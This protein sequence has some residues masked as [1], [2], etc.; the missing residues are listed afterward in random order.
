MYM[1]GVYCSGGIKWFGSEETKEGKEGGVEE[2]RF[3][4][5]TISLWRRF[6]TTELV[7]L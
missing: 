6:V 2:S 4:L 3:L 7:S 5:F 1:P